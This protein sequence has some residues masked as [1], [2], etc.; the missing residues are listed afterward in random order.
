VNE[1]RFLTEPG[2]VALHE[3]ALVIAFSGWFDAAGAA[4]AAVRHLTGIDDDLGQPVAEIDPEGFFDFT[5]RRPTVSL[6]ERGQRM[7]SWPTNRFVARSFAN[8]RDVVSLAGEEPHLRWSQFA[9]LVV[10]V[11]RAYECRMVV[12]LGAAI[13][14]VPHTRRP[15]V[16]GSTSSAAVAERLGLA[17]P[18][19]QGATGVIGILLQRCDHAG[20]PAISLRVEVPH[21]LAAVPHPLATV[22][23][24]ERLEPVLDVPTGHQEL[25]DD[26]NEWR[27]HHDQAVARDPEAVAYVERLEQAYDQRATEQLPSADELAAELED[28]LRDEESDE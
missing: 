10:E 5:R 11:G 27:R 7:V 17:M 26:V 24:L 22:A 9:D 12:T 20:L 21:Y 15:R 1:L 13:A 14:E 6:D 4:T 8:A 18:T 16:V 2:D 3:P 25:A 19:Y 23:I 28:F